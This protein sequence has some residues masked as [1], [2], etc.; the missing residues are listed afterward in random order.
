MHLFL[1][2][3]ELCRRDTS[4]LLT[5]GYPNLFLLGFTIFPNFRCERREREHFLLSCLYGCGNYTGESGI[6][7]YKLSYKAEVTKW[8]I[9][10]LW[11]IP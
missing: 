4:A 5:Q 9:P 10:D 11:M 6:R 8:K 1:H 3:W 2:P 7:S